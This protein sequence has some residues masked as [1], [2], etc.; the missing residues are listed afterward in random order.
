M[1]RLDVKIIYKTDDKLNKYLSQEKA[2]NW[3]I[4]NTILSYPDTIIS[5]RYMLS[6][7]NAIKYNY[8]YIIIIILAFP[9]ISQKN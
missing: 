9:E 7:I 4:T 2:Y 1:D 6:L 8:Y 3:G 5:E